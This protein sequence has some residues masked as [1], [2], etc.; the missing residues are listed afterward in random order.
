MF[1]A[2]QIVEDPIWV[3]IGVGEEEGSPRLPGD[4][5][6]PGPVGRLTGWERERKRGP[7]TRHRRQGHR[8]GG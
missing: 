1:A 3:L 8:D 7:R 4:P 5:T 2:V 6:H